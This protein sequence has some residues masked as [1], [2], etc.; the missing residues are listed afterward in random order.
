M[1]IHSLPSPCR[2]QGLSLGRQD[3]QQAPFLT[4]PFCWPH[5]WVVGLTVRGSSYNLNASIKGRTCSEIREASFSRPCRGKFEWYHLSAVWKQ[6]SAWGLRLRRG[7]DLIEL[8][9]EWQM[10]ADAGVMGLKF[11][12]DA[13]PS[14]DACRVL[15][16][17]LCCRVL[18][19]FM[20][21]YGLWFLLLHIFIGGNTCF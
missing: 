17:R 3:S 8:G 15:V 2:S 12:R 6:L 13:L 11:L 10:P 20:S 21:S 9:S 5:W 1:G 16:V 18:S 19:V 7:C 14:K 4:D